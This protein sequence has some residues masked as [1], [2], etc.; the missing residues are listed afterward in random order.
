MK[1]S[2]LLGLM[3][4]FAFSCRKAPLVEDAPEG[5]PAP[6]T[7]ESASARVSAPSGK[8][9]TTAE[10]QPEN[11]R[12]RPLPRPEDPKHK[13]APPSDTSAPIAVAVKDKPGF[14][15]SP[16]NDKFVDVR[17]IPPGTLAA[18]PTYPLTEKKYFRVP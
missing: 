5:R 13:P 14:V 16:F 12:S 8:P 18:D 17:D 4:L 7:R 1:H 9:E 11:P 10:V 6:T 15:M 3:V 2:A